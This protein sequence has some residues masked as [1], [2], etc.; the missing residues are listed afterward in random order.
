MAAAVAACRAGFGAAPVL[1]R[2]GG[3]IPAVGLLQGALG[4][5]P[6][7][8]GFALPDDGAHAPDERLHLPTF[9]SAIDTS[10]VLLGELAGQAG[11]AP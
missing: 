9:W 7:L 4:H 2:A 11:W 1:L 6:L 10:I 8:L 5:P 3:T